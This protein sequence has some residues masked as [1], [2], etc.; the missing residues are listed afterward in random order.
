M[1]SDLT[2]VKA[3][4]TVLNDSSTRR[5]TNIKKSGIKSPGGLMVGL[6]VGGLSVKW[7]GSL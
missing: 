2:T 7:V 1:A 4:Q 5:K 3:S 6:T